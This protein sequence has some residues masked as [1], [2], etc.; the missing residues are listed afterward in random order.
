[1]DDEV[2]AGRLPFAVPLAA[3]R[4]RIVCSHPSD[5]LDAEHPAPVAADNSF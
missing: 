1:M 4:G 2:N 5:E 3:R